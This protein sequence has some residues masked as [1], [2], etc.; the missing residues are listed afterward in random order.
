VRK[1]GICAE[2]RHFFLFLCDII[3]FKKP[4]VKFKL[5]NFIFLLIIFHRYPIYFK[6][7]VSDRI[8]EQKRMP[9]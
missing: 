9:F 1:T 4:L 3:A 2:K 6:K 8:F 7:R 5:Q